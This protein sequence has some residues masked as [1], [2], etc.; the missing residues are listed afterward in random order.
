MYSTGYWIEGN[1]NLLISDFVSAQ[2]RLSAGS[3]S[4]CQLICWQCPTLSHGPSNVSQRGW[5][6][7][8]TSSTS[9]SSAPSASTTSS[10]PAAPTAP[11]APTAQPASSPRTSWSLPCTQK[12]ACG[13][14]GWT[15]SKGL[16]PCFICRFFSSVLGNMFFQW[17]VCWLECLLH[18]P[19][20]KAAGWGA[21]VHP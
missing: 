9:A 2:H 3:T 18:H 15:G 20:G 16:V 13:S 8:A 12:H 17:M 10:A 7:H 19:T 5:W 21:P 14:E 6:S 1:C 11:T 4:S